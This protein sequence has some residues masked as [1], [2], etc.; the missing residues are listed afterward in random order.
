MRRGGW[1]AEDRNCFGGRSRLRICGLSDGAFGFADAF[2]E[3]FRYIFD[4]DVFASR[5][6]G[7]AAEHALAEGAADR[8]DF[9]SCCVGQRPLRLPKAVVGD[10]L[11]AGFFFFPEL[12]AAGSAT[13][14]VFTV[15]RELDDRGI[16]DVEQV[17]GCIVDAVVAAK[18]TGIVIGNRRLGGGWR[19][20]LVGDERLEIFSV[21]EDFIV[22]PNL[23]VLMA[24]GV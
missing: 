12:G 11:I 19:E 9:L 23:F 16:Q 10:A 4:N 21:M 3:K 6:A 24:E 14:R 5:F 13:E 2:E 22:A 20:L 7:C 18:I 17:A 1:C 15:A 8:E